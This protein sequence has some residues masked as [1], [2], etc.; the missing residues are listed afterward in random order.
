MKFSIC[1]ETF[2]GWSWEQTCSFAAECGYDGLEVAPYTMAEDVRRLDIEARSTYR[3][4]AE[5]H[6]LEVVGLHWLLLSPRGL[7]MT[8]P[9]ECLRLRTAEYLADLVDFCADLGGHVMVLG[10]P[11]QRRVP[12]GDTIEVAADRFID[13]VRPAL[14]R[15]ERRDVFLCLEPL[16][17][18]EAN[19]LLTL[20]E[21]QA[22]IDRLGH[23]C[24][25]TVFDVKS[26]SAEGEP[27]DTLYRRYAPIVAHCHAN[28]ANRRGPG[29]G[30]TDFRPLLSALRAANYGGY[31][32]VE[33]FD[34][35]PDPQTVASKS[36]EYLRS[37]L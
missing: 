25:R 6:G 30:D 29:F 32:S 17:A 20:A 14:E 18:P 10:S 2:Q 1:N 3:S 23:A 12:D 4:V 33:P 13:V 7:S 8:S 9:D 27:L 11:N 26:A 22:L 37:C 5:Q 36:L 21:A 15:C 16:P 19:F 35:H 34:Y 31:V 24:T 28:D